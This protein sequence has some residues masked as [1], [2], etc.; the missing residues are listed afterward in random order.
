MR[1]EAFTIVVILAPCTV[2]VACSAAPDDRLLPGRRAA[3]ATDSESLAAGE[4]NMFDHQASGMGS[5]NGYTDPKVKLAQDLL[6]GSPDTVARLH[7]TTKIRYAALGT[8]LSGWGVN[9]ASKTANSAGALYTGGSSAL[10]AP[11]FAN[12]VPEQT[13]PSTSS[14]AK[15]FDI[16]A[17]ASS[18]IVTAFGTS[19]R[20]QGLTLVDANNQFNADAISCLIGK[21]AKADHLTL[22]NKCVGEA[23]TP[24][25]GVQIAVTTMLSAAHTSE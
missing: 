15:E 4:S 8:M 16:F 11:N 19:T 5:D 10:G 13:I 1:T 14:L 7:G 12:R 6:I 24:Q 18:E 20:C 2:L 17:A 9:T 21:P 3:M 23:S 25:I 22:A